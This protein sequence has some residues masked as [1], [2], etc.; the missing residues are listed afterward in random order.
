MHWYEKLLDLP[1]DCN[2]E[3]CSYPVHKIYER[4]AEMYRIGSFGLEKDLI[5]SSEHY[6]SA[7]DAALSSMKGKLANRYYMLAEEVSE[8]I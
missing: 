8:E 7:A 6:N 2:E 4:L 1:E 3:L 5:K